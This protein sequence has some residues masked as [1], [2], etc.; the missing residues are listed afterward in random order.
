M[1]VAHYSPHRLAYF[2]HKLTL[3]G[4]SDPMERMAGA[5]AAQVGLFDA[6]VDA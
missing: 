1:T 6:Q 5:R 2:A 4:A 3:Q